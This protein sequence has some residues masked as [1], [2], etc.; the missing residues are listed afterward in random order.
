MKKWMLIVLAA[1][2]ISAAAW[3][4][5]HDPVPMRQDIKIQRMERGGHDCHQMPGMG[6]GQWWEN[7]MVVKELG[8]SEAQS[9]QIDDLSLKHRKDIVKLE[10]DIKIAEMDLWNLI[11]DNGSEADIRKKAKEL[12]QLREKIQEM[13]IDHMLS[14]RKI[15]TSEQQK[16]LKELRVLPSL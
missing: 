12:S 1:T 11:G 10:A 4:Q 15:L 16:K 7:P 8:L 13:R 9:K 6:R 3:A 14:L 5:C 2:A